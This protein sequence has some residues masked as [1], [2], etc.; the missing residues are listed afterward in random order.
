MATVAAR[1]AGAEEAGE[2]DGARGGAGEAEALFAEGVMGSRTRRQ[3]LV[4]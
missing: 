4:S 1:A 2:A 3:H